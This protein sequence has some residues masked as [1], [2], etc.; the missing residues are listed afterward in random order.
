VRR[1]RAA[2]IFFLLLAAHHL[3]AA[4]C[5]ELFRASSGTLVTIP[6][7]GCALS[8][9]FTLRHPGLR[10]VG[11]TPHAEI[12]LTSDAAGLRIENARDV[13]VES[14][15]IRRNAMLAGPVADSILVIGD[16]PGFV[17]KD[18]TFQ[19]SGKHLDLSGAH[20][21]LIQNTHHRGSKT[22]GFVIYCYQCRNGVIDAT[23][24]DGFVVPAGGPFRAIEILKSEKIRVKDPVIRDIDARSQ[25][26]YAGVDFT[27]SHDSSLSGGS[28][29]GLINSDGVL[30]GRST[31]IAISNVRIENNSGH[32]QQIVGGGTG[33]GIDV[34]G[35]SHV[36]ISKCI[37]RHNGHSPNPGTRHHGLELYQ[38]NDLEITDTIAD[39]S[40]KNGIFIYGS[41]RVKIVGGSASR[42]H[43]AGLYAFQAAG[44]ADVAGDIVTLPPHDTFGSK[45]QAG[46]PIKIGGAT[47]RIAAVIDPTHLRLQR[48]IGDRKNVKWS[49]QSSV[50]LIGGAYNENGN[51]RLGRGFEEGILIADQTEARLE[52]VHATDDRPA[53]QR[54]QRTNIRK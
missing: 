51:A 38:S 50:A 9:L 32:P 31:Q 44:R 54:T 29:T 18:I 16:S 2:L 21:F 28:I 1:F 35:A 7:E 10:I 30:V 22:D 40:G 4:Q 26:N 36:T 8:T 45:W 6:A 33:S 24:I 41:Q 48:S 27:D 23:Q 39:D 12:Y 17:A 46:T 52:G 47:E 20:D 25:A 53:A 19:D 5:E 34:F 13:H 43:E 42:N 14:L 11:A 15:T 3:R 49:V 37:V